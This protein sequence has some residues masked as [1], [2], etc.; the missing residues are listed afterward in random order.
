[1][2]TIDTWRC[3]AFIALGTTSRAEKKGRTICSALL[4]SYQ[5]GAQVARQ[6]CLILRLG[7]TNS[8]TC[9]PYK[10]RTSLLWRK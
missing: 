2:A 1:M 10:N 6:R 7:T 5:D 8:T 9:P 3:F 4:Y